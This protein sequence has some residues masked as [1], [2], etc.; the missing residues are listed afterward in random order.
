MGA[1]G[2]GVICSSNIFVHI[3]FFCGLR[4]PR[5]TSKTFSKIPTV[6]LIAYSSPLF[7][8]VSNFLSCSISSIRDSIFITG[9]CKT[10]F[11]RLPFPLCS[12]PG[13]L[14]SDFPNIGANRE[15]ICLALNSWIYSLP[16]VFVEYQVPRG[17]RVLISELCFYLVIPILGGTMA[18]WGVCFPIGIVFSLNA[19]KLRPYLQKFK[20]VF[21]VLTASIFVIAL[22]DARSIVTAPLARFISPII[23]LFIIPVINRNSIPGVRP[24]E[25]IGKR[26]YGIYLSHLIILDITLRIFSE[27]FPRLFQYNFLLYPILFTIGLMIPISMMNFTS[28]SPARKYYRLYLADAL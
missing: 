24:L 6:W 23:F 8:V 10:T 21:A 28:R 13:F 16:V 12:P 25:K 14:L 17:F 22:L 11:G 1:T 5:G 4:R 18:D 26:S 19:M 20:W 27:V 9:I 3:R 2:F 7:A 15:A